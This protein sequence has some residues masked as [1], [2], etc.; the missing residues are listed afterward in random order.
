[1][2]RVVTIGGSIDFGCF[3]QSDCASVETGCE[4]NGLSAVTAP[5]SDNKTC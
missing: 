2:M 1:M 5:R 4:N 3:D